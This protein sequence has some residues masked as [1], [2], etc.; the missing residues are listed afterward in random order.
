MLD[1]QEEVKVK[2]TLIMQ[3]T[4][5]TTTTIDRKVLHLHKHLEMLTML[6]L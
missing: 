5:T 2:E 3:T 4:T 1:N 6:S